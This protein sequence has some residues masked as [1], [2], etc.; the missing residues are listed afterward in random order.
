MHLWYLPH[1][2]TILSSFSRRSKF[3]ASSANLTFTDTQTTRLD[4]SIGFS[5]PMEYAHWRVSRRQRQGCARIRNNGMAR[6]IPHPASALASS[7]TIIHSFLSIT[8]TDEYGGMI[9]HRRSFPR[10]R[11]FEGRRSWKGLSTSSP[12]SCRFFVATLLL[13]RPERFCGQMMI[14]RACDFL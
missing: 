13:G 5:I 7:T 3:S 8:G 11:L 9:I 2:P 1:Y 6:Y 10:D 4:G 12:S 14:L